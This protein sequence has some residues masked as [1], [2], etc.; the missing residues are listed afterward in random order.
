APWSGAC[1]LR[2]LP[3]LRLAA[4]AA[5]GARLRSPLESPST[6]FTP[7][8]RT[9]RRAPRTQF[10]GKFPCRCRRRRR[11]SAGG[12]GLKIFRPSK[13]LILSKLLDFRERAARLM[14]YH[15]YRKEGTASL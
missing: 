14:V 4:P 8:P 12:D 1:V 3:L 11:M 6:K 9:R 7:K 15:G 10:W 2:P 5:G 13:L